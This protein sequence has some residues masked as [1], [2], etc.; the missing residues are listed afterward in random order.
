[1]RCFEGQNLEWEGSTR[2]KPWLKAIEDQQ[3][4]LRLAIRPTICG[5]NKI[6]GHQ[7]MGL[8]IIPL[9]TKVGIAYTEV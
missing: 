2:M 4:R 5:K 8:I 3:F 7:F 6:F 1:M 9:V